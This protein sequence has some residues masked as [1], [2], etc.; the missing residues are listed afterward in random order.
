M[1]DATPIRLLVTVQ[2]YRPTRRYYERKRP[3]TAVERCVY[4]FVAWTPEQHYNEARLP[5]AGSFL[6]PG[7]HAAR[8]EAM[9]YLERPNVQQVSVR[10]NQ[11]RTVYLFKRHADGRITGYTPDQDRY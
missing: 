11:D 5:C 6:F 10:T 1:S 3:Y 4:G 9:R 7:V 2:G 8:A